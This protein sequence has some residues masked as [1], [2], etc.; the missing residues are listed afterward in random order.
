MTLSTDPRFNPCVW[1]APRLLKQLGFP[2]DAT[3]PDV[4]PFIKERLILAHRAQDWT[5]AAIW[6]RVKSI[7]WKRLPNIC[8]CG[9]RITPSSTLCFECNKLTPKPKT[10]KYVGGPMNYNHFLK[11]MLDDTKDGR[12]LSRKLIT[13]ELL[14]AKPH[15]TPV[16][17]RDGIC[18]A[19]Q[20]FV[21]IKRLERLSPGLFRKVQ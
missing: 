2:K 10:R 15:L 13:A 1:L 18:K 11:V 5:Q 9:K 8:G 14:E 16:Q 21:R 17:A 7:M 20:H 19:L 3:W 6:S 4:A 12:L